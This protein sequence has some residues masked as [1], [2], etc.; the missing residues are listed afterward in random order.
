MQGTVTMRHSERFYDGALHASSLFVL[1][2]AV[3]KLRWGG[4]T[5]AGKAWRVTILILIE[6]EAS[7]RMMGE[8]RTVHPSQKVKGAGRVWARKEW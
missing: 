1:P 6:A 2:N 5:F 4:L 8:R 7:G 3:R